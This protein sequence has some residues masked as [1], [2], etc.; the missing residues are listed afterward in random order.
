M[1]KVTLGRGDQR[2]VLA[3]SGASWALEPGGTV[4][5]AAA[6]HLDTAV[7][8]PAGAARRWM[9][10]G[11]FGLVQGL[12]FASALT[13]LGLSREALVRALI[14]FN[15]GV[16]LGQL[17]FVAVVMPLLV[18][19]SRPVRVP[20]LPQILSVIVAM[21]GAVWLVERLLAV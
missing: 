11:F 21:V 18:W 14:G 4:E 1:Q 16:E 15:I 5:G 8:A 7:V 12:G 2:L 10:A 6:T 9:I 17:A 3:R 13:E 19:A 20:R